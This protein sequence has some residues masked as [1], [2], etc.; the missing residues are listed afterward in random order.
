MKRYCFILIALALIF[1]GCGGKDKIKPSDDS[2]LAMEAFD[3]IYIIKA[4]YQ[5]R[6]SSALKKR[7][8]PELAES[9][10]NNLLFEKAELSFTPK[11]VR[12]KDSSVIVDLNWQGTWRISKE[13][14]LK[15][16]GTANLELEKET[17]KLLR[18]DGD[19]P[20]ITLSDETEKS[21]EKS[22]DEKPESPAGFDINPDNT[23][24]E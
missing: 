17:M 2:R 13:E 7:L 3:S 21:G 1:S 15:R 24:I 16:R 18:I 4:A 14:K 20:F 11:I 22:Q 9:I 8:A 5:D 12:I 6:N 10:L 19:N 23:D